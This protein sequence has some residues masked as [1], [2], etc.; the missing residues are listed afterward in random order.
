MVLGGG[1]GV[2]V[3]VAGASHPSEVGGLGL[4][5]KRWLGGKSSCS[6]G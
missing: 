2:G 3:L 4:L 6:F 5:E 1:V